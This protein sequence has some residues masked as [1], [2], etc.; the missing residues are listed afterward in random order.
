M[1]PFSPS[2][3]LGA[4]VLSV[5]I[6]AG[7]LIGSFFA[8]AQ[9][10]PALAQA[11]TPTPT[12]LLTPTTPP[13]AP[14]NSAITRSVA[15]S[16][17]GS[18]DVTPDLAVLSLGVRTEADTAREA[19]TQNN[20]QMQALIDS[21]RQA[22]VAQADIQTRTIQIYPRYRTPPPGETPPDTP[23]VD[24]YI[25]MNSVDVTIRDLENLGELLDNA[26]TAGGNQIEGLR[27]DVSDP[28]AA[29]EQ[30]REAAMQDARGK[31]EQL[32]GLAGAALGPVIAINESSLPPVT[33]DLMA[34]DA[35]ARGGEAVPVAPGS[36]RVE[37]NVQVTWELIPG[38]E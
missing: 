8:G 11:A 5:L 15:V 19:L 36:Q 30:A 26:V 18:V 3:I 1:N 22:G 25:A 13:N 28:R 37:V 14:P 35:S 34:V 2:K 20:T 32:A 12:A 17:S 29:Q 33:Y 10:Q 27:F 9:A 16:G 38:S 31:A 7:L 6:M 23:T 21:I 24:G 4:A